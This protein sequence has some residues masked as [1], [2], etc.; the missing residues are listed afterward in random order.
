MNS[1]NVQI[2]NHPKE[3]A[4]VH[5]RKKYLNLAEPWKEKLSAKKGK[6]GQVV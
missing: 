5:D 2:V 4:T 1:S 6:I 3:V